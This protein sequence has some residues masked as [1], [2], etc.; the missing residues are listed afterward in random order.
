MNPFDDPE[1]VARYAEGPPRLV[2]GFAGLL[3]MTTLLLAERAPNDAR[4]LVVGAGGGLELKAFAEAHP[5]WRFDGVDPAAAMLK[6][7]R[8]TLGS[9][10]AR[11]QLHE[12]YIDAAPEGPFDAATCLLTLHFVPREERHRTL[13]E[14]RRRL[15]PGA[16]FVVAHFSIPQGENERALWLSRYADFAVA[17]G[18]ERE[19]AEK[20][21]AALGTQLVIL[22]PEQDEVMLREAGFS[23][24]SLFY[25][26]FTFR[27]WVAYA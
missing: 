9:L 13:M 25:A 23:N 5:G 18:I 1:A 2:P 21:R 26:A 11:V 10:A 12:G 16:P 27:G 8:A 22:S 7:A 20:A 24:V 14:V 6:L 17:S 15:K 4:V 19:K 3:R